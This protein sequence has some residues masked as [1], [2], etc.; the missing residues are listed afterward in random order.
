[1]YGGRHGTVWHYLL[2][3]D[4][5][6]KVPDGRPHVTAKAGEGREVTGGP[7]QRKKTIRF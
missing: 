2:G 5:A 7:S 6:C 1:V 3:V 4:D